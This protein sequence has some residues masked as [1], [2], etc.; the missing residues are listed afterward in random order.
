VL[1]KTSR[2]FSVIALSPS[3]AASAPG[4]AGAGV[5]GTSDSSLF[6]ADFGSLLPD[7]T[8][9]NFFPLFSYCWEEKANHGE[10]GRATDC[11]QKQS[12][13]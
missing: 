8:L 9:T 6:E 5:E 2:S 1:R 3:A 10:G 11:Q 7:L 4:G 12:L 13:R